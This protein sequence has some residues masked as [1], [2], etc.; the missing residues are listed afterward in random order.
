MPL[1]EAL[2]GSAGCCRV[3]L[4]LNQLEES[5]AREISRFWECSLFPVQKQLEK[6]KK[7]GVLR[8]RTAG[9][10]LLYSF[11]PTCPLNREIRHLLDRCMS[12]IP[13]ETA[14][15]FMSLV[16]AMHD[17]PRGENLRSR[18]RRSICRSRAL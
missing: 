2:L 11:D 12:H 13:A 8:S 9:R 15:R 14:L 16:S 17:Y 10:T 18:E 5:Y 6:L 1:L 4:L 3:L 7:G